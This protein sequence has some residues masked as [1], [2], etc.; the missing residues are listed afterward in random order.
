[1]FKRLTRQ[2]VDPR[3]PRTMGACADKLY[4]LR[5]Q[6]LALQKDVDALQA[7][8]SALREHIIATLPL[9]DATGVK[10]KLA[11]IT[12]NAKVHV[13]VRDWTKLLAYIH[14]NKA[15][16]LL[17]RRV[18]ELAIKARWEDKQKVPGTEP[19]QDKEISCSKLGGKK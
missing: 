19:Y 1:M 11:Q 17:Q 10:G 18:N 4:T 14:K 12:I 2:V 9:S 3:F 6:R 16:D 15:F 8:E 13:T 5:E 7:E